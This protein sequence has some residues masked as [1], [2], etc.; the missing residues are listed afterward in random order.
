MKASNEETCGLY[1]CCIKRK[2]RFPILQKFATP[3]WALFILSLGSFVQGFIVNGLVNGVLATLV[4]RFQ[5][6]ESHAGIISCGYDIGFVLLIPIFMFFGEKFS[7]PR[8]IGYGMI[9]M[10]IG[11][12]IFS[13]PHFIAPKLAATNYTDS[14]CRSN[15][16]NM[17]NAFCERDINLA[18]YR[19]IFIF[20]Q[21]LVGMGSAP[22][23]TLGITYIDENVKRHQSSLY[24]G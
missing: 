11:T 1:L 9:M 10:G 21:L 2:I 22:L 19:F 3:L 5:M 17:T 20:G 7:K 12:L 6:K 16:V 18:D 13:L 4:R 8:A 23:F 15:L 24:H 14:I